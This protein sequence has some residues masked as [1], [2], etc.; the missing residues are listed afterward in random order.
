MGHNLKA[1]LDFIKSIGATV[2]A[3]AG[4]LATTISLVQLSRL[5]NSI[6]WLVL[7]VFGVGVLWLTCF[8]VVF[9]KKPAEKS[10]GFN[11]QSPEAVRYV[12]GKK[13]RSIG[14]IGILT[15]PVLCGTGYFAIRYIRNLPSHKTIIMVANF[16]SLDG[17]NY[18][19]AE[20]IIED[21]RR[22]TMQYGDV[23]IRGLNMSITARDGAERARL[24]G[25]EH[26]VTI[27]LWGWYR[28]TNENVLVSTHVEILKKPAALILRSDS[29]EL[30][31]P[32]REI[33]SFEVHTRL[34]HDLTYLTLL[35]VGLARMESKK[36]QDAI[37]LFTRAIQL[38]TAPESLIDPGNVY[39]FRGIAYSSIRS[40]R[41]AID[42]F[43]K[44]LS[45][46]S[47]PCGACALNN[48]AI[49]Y[50]HLGNL[51]SALSDFLQ[52]RERDSK[53]TFI[54]FNLG[55]VYRQRGESDK[56]IQSFTEAVNR[57][58]EV[59]KLEP[60][61]W[62]VLKNRGLAFVQLGNFDQGIDDLNRSILLKQQ[63]GQAT[64]ADGRSFINKKVFIRDM[65]KY[66]QL[67][68]S[69]PD[70]EG[71][72]VGR[73]MLYISVRDYVKAIDDL[74]KAIGYNPEYAEAFHQRGKAKEALG[75]GDE[76]KSDFQKF[77][78]LSRDA[79]SRNHAKE[80]LERLGVSQ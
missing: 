38:S 50:A 54:H 28:K 33:D 46:T 23:E 10:V 73:A 27:L 52:S 16:E 3:V 43:T 32:A 74:D 19:V 9:K 69:Q 63:A 60:D 13:T 26:Q 29:H 5:E 24:I 34:S 37:S 68:D 21:L 71:A 1:L 44:S 36:Y 53:S 65:A 72:Y 80:H 51:D 79:N 11:T 78:D 25:A 76:A 66:S 45:L 56:A 49:A 75:H 20:K 48:R 59:L 42:D 41:D 70:S 4:F 17:Q 7:L 39:L 31:R 2:L 40:Y 12:F 18:G 61:N 8:Y 57:S 47:S 64:E 62:G 15:V 35:T 55:V 22:E 67:L 58:N 14:L 6:F 77:L 30:I